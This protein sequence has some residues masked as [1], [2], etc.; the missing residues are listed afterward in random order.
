M[1][2][3]YK[4]L[5]FSF[6]TILISCEE[7]QSGIEPD[8]S[9]GW[10][11]MTIT[12]QTLDSQASEVSI[13]VNITAPT[14]DNLSIGYTITAIS[15]DLSQYGI[16][17]SGTLEVK[18][19]KGDN[20]RI[21]PIDLIIENTDVLHDELVFDVTLSTSSNPNISV[22]INGD[23]TIPT[24]SRVTI[25]CFGEGTFDQIIAAEPDFLIGQY[26]LSEDPNFDR[27]IPMFGEQLVT[28]FPGLNPNERVFDFILFPGTG[29]ASLATL[30]F[31]IIEDAELGTTIVLKESITTGLACVGGVP[32]LG[33]N[34][35]TIDTSDPDQAGISYTEL[36][37][38]NGGNS[39]FT[40]NY[41]ETQ[42]GCRNDGFTSF[43][44]SK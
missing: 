23:S 11:E 15:G 27:I 36:S 13:P 26:L 14:F 42:G 24:V 33:I 10:L 17:S 25:P 43:T 44:L 12:Q 34:T 9:L 29:F 38:C 30:T 3:I 37:I 28:I 32:G 2:K 40:V 31:E 22:G 6:L 21:F 1:K 20:R 16:A 7:E 19:E 41:F 39:S 5:L 8:L 35:Y 18:P 4:I